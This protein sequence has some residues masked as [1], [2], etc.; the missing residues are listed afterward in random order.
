MFIC[1]KYGLN[2]K[3]YFLNT[4]CSSAVL[5]DY[6]QERTVRDTRQALEE[7]REQEK[8]EKARVI[9]VTQAQKRSLDGMVLEFRDLEKAPTE[10]AAAEAAM[11]RKAYLEEEI[12]RK[13]KDMENLEGERK[14]RE[15]ALKDLEEKLDIVSKIKRVELV[16]D[17]GG[18]VQ[19]KEPEQKSG[20][21]IA[22]KFLAPRSTVRVKA[23]AEAEEDEGG[24][25]AFELSFEI[26]PIETVEVEA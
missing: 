9:K 18:P 24:E 12:E 8:K 23:Y 1:A 15:D 2:D 21:D 5:S 4:N 22:A 7:R 10:G 25:T 20:G 3:E 6:V 11:Q 19:L 16:E 17:G 14:A 26:P 13:K